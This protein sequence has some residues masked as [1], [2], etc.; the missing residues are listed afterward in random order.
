MT[1]KIADVGRE[2]PGVRIVAPYVFGHDDALKSKNAL[3]DDGQADHYGQQFIDPKF[4]LH[5]WKKQFRVRSEAGKNSCYDQSE[6]DAASEYTDLR[7]P[8]QLVFPPFELDIHER[9]LR[10]AFYPIS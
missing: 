5:G 1:I 8:W 7:P 9:T 10:F 4:H 2:Q 3:L 6:G